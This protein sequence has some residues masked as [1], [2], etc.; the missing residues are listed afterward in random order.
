MPA[1][2]LALVAL[3]ALVGTVSTALVSASGTWHHVVASV[4]VL[5]VDQTK[6]V[7]L[8]AA[9][10][11]SAFVFLLKNEQE[12]RLYLLFIS[13]QRCQ[14]KQNLFVLRFYSPVNSLGSCRVRSVYLT[15]L[16][17]GQA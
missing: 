15:T 11:F 7:V 4:T 5:L 10:A 2:L 14:G 16:F 6:N 3:S 17:P 13:R 1:P 9:L 8:W 12:I